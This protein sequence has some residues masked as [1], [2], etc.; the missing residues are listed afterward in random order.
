MKI[1]SKLAAGLAV[2]VLFLTACTDYGTDLSKEYKKYWKYTFD[3]DYKMEQTEKKEEAADYGSRTW[4]V[5]YTNK[6]GQA[7]EDT[8][9][10]S[11]LNNDKDNDIIV[12]QFAGRAMSASAKDELYAKLIEK[13]FPVKYKAGGDDYSIFNGDGYKLEMYGVNAKLSALDED[14]SDDQL[15]KL[16]S[17]DDGY[18][19]MDYDLKKFMSEEQDLIYVKVNLDSPMDSDKAESSMR[20]LVKE[21]ENYAGKPKNYIFTVNVSDKY[22]S[23]GDEVYSKKVFMGKENSDISSYTDLENKV[24]S[25]LG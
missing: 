9:S 6:A 1:K 19:I 22:S 11:G 16:L 12:L 21:F 18:K 23:S 2:G 24:Q 20:N 14:S 17:T 4:T 10:T 8:I 3:G 5:S 13:Y 7:H 15:E 25:K